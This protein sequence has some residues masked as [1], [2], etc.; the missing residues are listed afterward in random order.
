LYSLE[1]IPVNARGFFPVRG[2]GGESFFKRTLSR[3]K[4]KLTPE[5]GGFCGGK[6]NLVANGCGG[7]TSGG[8][9]CLGPLETKFLTKK[10]ESDQKK[11]TQKKKEEKTQKIHKSSFKKKG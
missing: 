10:S 2:G 4:R 7:S 5:R 8:K 11:E 1:P 9:S 3:K 6:K